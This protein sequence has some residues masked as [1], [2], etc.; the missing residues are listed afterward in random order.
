MFRAFSR[1]IFKL[2]GWRV[3]DHRGAEA[4]VQAIYVVAPHTSNWDFV[5]GVFARSIGRIGHARY[6]AKASLFKP[7]FGW[8]FKALGGYPVDRTK[9]TNLTDQV[10]A[11]FRDIPGFSI[12]ITPE[13]TRKHVDQWKTGFWH[14]AKAAHVPLI[15]VSFDY[16]RKEITLN[17]PWWPTD[18]KDRDIA[19]L[20][21]YFKPFR[22]KN[23]AEGVR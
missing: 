5:L 17:K 16:A 22:G 12:A 13:G 2:I 4:H 21:A 14:I 11:Y 1:A 8:I 9:S 23:A 7:P 6:L 10:A 18:D 19:W 3:V 20:M 15:L